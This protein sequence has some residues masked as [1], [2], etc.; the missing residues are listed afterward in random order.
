VRP[1]S[2]TRDIRATGRAYRSGP[3]RDWIKVKNPE[4]PAMV[5]HREGRWW[6]TDTEF[7]AA[8][9]NRSISGEHSIRS[10][11]TKEVDRHPGLLKHDGYRL[12][13]G[14][15]SEG[16]RNHLAQPAVIPPN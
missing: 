8:P 14:W 10:R 3:S 12:I 9:R 11:R 13:M 15:P 2:L 5:R 7:T 16:G 6:R 4:S 1:R